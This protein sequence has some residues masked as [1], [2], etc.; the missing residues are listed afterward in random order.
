MSVQ[1]FKKDVPIKII[2]DFLD[3]CATRKEGYY[4]FSKVSFKAAQ[5]NNLIVP[6]CNSLIEY[7]YKSKR[8]Y[9]LRPMS[10]TNF[11]TI[12]RQLCKKVGLKFT[13][14]IEYEKSTYEIIYNIF[15][16]A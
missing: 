16:D 15:Y 7:Y 2:T 3:S 11:N 1:I 13:S 8:V 6:F 12:L 14:K 5:F 9:I 10:Y 4:I